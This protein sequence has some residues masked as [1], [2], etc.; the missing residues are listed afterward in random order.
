MINIRDFLK[1]RVLLFDGAMGTYYARIS[2]DM[3][4]GCEQANIKRPDIIR[5]IHREYIDAGAMAIKT[6]TF[7]LS[8]FDT[9]HEEIQKRN[10][11]ISAGYDIAT[12]AAQDKAYVFADIGPAA[13]AS[14]SETADIYIS[15]AEIFLK[16]G[17][18]NYIFETLSGSEGILKAAEFIKNLKPSAFIIVSFAVLPDGYTRDG[19]Y[20]KDLIEKMQKSSVI[21]AVG[22]NCISGAGQMYELVR[23]FDL[24][25]IFESGKYLSVM[26]NAGYPVIRGNQSVFDGNDTYFAS[27]LKQI[28]SYGVRIIGGC[29][30]TTPEYIKKVAQDLSGEAPKSVFVEK[31]KPESH[32]SIKKYT[33]VFFD[34]L[35][36]WKDT[37]KKVIA[38]ELDPPKDGDAQLF[39]QNAK[40]LKDIGIDILTI[41]DC[42]IARARM[43]S[44]LLSCK[45]KRELSMEVL[46]HLTCRDRNINATK[47]LLLGLYSEGVHNVLAVTGDPVPTAERSEVNAVYQ[48]NSRKLASYITSLN[49]DIFNDSIKIFTALNINSKNFSAELKRAQLKIE[50]GSVGFLT[51]PAYSQESFEN[52]K[53]ARCKLDALILGGVIP[54]ISKRNAVFMHNEVNGISI[55][56]DIIDSFENL[57]P[58]ECKKHAIKLCLDVAA[59][60]YE[61]VD[62]YYI[63]T[64]FQKIDIIEKII[65][66]IR[67]GVNDYGLR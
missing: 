3:S 56:E 34:R 12:E 19:R 60:M 4:L 20:Y 44:S 1:R 40:R 49:K 63:I 33:N 14:E 29:C 28:Y 62:G 46:P 32:K 45:I 23:E 52:L 67:Q 25:R 9:S 17:A 21:D 38:V 47:A 26:P 37:S 39:L 59:R 58:D 42:P 55:P 18:L 31:I 57:T 11:L 2:G 54:L 50:C 13:G 15:Q 22:I 65:S 41:S 10:E 64:P 51:Q 8:Y 66:G 7:G 53:M 43:D 30:G 36:T 48:F 6:N 16:K 61:D 24:L 5:N 27:K 35:K